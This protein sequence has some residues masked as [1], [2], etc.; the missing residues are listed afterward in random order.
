MPSPAPTI[1]SDAHAHGPVA[2]EL[3]SGRAI[4]TTAIVAVTEPAAADAALGILRDELLAIDRTCS[5]FRPDSEICALRRANG[6]RM[7]VSALLFEAIAV[8]CDVAQRTGGAVDPTVG[9]AMETLGYDRDLDQLDQVDQLDRVGPQAVGAPTPAPGWWQIELD[10]RRRTVR[11]PAGTHLDLGASAKA[12]VADRAATRIAGA[13][14]TGVL[15][16]IGGDVAVAGRAPD[17]GWAVGIAADSSADVADVD[18]VVAIES[19][20]LATSSTS[21][22]TWE[23]GGHPLHH[24]VDPATGDNAEA[25]WTTVSASGATCVDANAASTAAVVWG[26]QAV[27]KL[28]EL[29]A[30]ARLVRTDGRLVVMNGWPLPTGPWPAPVNGSEV[31]P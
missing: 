17:G 1:V 23:R 26:A 31:A 22:R 9:V 4:G 3:R 24:I 28:R 7:R 16:S 21:V 10:A 5:R 12:L 15:V 29:G 27:M 11:A 2:P 30:P 25:Y 6:A 18:Q 8:A 14:R 19:G 20:G 13:L